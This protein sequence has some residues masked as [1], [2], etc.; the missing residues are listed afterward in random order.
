MT[1]GIVGLG[2]IGGSF[3]RALSGNGY[4]VIGF[5]TNTDTLKQALAEEAISSAGEASRDL[6]QCDAVLVCLYPVGAVDFVRDNA[7]LFKKSALLLDMAGVKVSVISGIRA[8]L[9]ANNRTD[10]RYVGC[11]PMAGREFSGF[12]YSTNTLFEG[13]SFIITRSCDSSEADLLEVQKIA[14]DSGFS[15]TVTTSPE[16]HDRIVAYTSQLAHVISSCYIKSP[17]LREE[18]ALRGFTA[19]SFEDMTRVARLQETMWTELFLM[20]K[21]ALIAE[22][23]RFTTDLAAY[24]EAISSSDEQKLCDLLKKGRE[25][26]ESLLK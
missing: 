5:D 24:R 6:P 7:P 13:R 15:R 19:G 16:E 9:N 12:S 4:N 25:I 20:N 21:S 17:V 8:A 26:K 2:L 23:D 10:V 11:H 22:I 14:L 3:A 18:N 1:I